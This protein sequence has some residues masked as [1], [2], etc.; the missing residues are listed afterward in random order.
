MFRGRLLATRAVISV[1]LSRHSY[2]NHAWPD[3]TRGVRISSR[4]RENARVDLVPTSLRRA[5]CS[6][7]PFYSL[8]RPQTHLSARIKIVLHV[9]MSV[10]PA[11]TSAITPPLPANLPKPLKLPWPFSST[12]QLKWQIIY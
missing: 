6:P 11:F 2:A 7:L 1:F 5:S 3:K 10:S 12:S 4:K 9:S 8:P